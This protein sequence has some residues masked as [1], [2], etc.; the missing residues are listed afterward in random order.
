MIVFSEYSDRLA[1]SSS[2]SDL[3]VATEA[4]RVAGCAVYSIPPNFDECE[5]AE[6]A[7]AHVGAQASL[8]PATWIG[9]IPSPER[10]SA[11]YRAALAKNIRL[12]NDPDQFER[13]MQLDRACPFL[14]GLTP[15]CI[16]LTRV[17]QA[18]SAARCLGLPVFVKG[19]V[20]S[21]KALGWRACVAATTEE[22]SALV[23]EML[24]SEWEARGRVLVRPLVRLRHE[25]VSD[26]GF[27]LGREYR[28]FL[29]QAE[30][31][32]H[33]YYWDGDDPL[34]K[35]E[36]HE[37]LDL[38]NLAT[39]AA[40]RIGVPFV[41]L[42]IGQLEAGEWIVIEP[43]DGQFAGLSQVSPLRLWNNLHQAVMRRVPDSSLRSE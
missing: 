3:R 35:L 27:P 15:E 28:I 18:E 30:V 1:Y 33:G 31:L 26:Q 13:A 36:P 21:R 32:A 24:T 37:E 41:A 40:T 17:E 16:V 22:L 4:A 6:N 11:I 39:T 5:T 34:S 29:F 20:R 25:R 43:G 9:F 42:D 14:E 8:R 10:Y 19:A 7:L 12:L 23:S 38:L 2:L